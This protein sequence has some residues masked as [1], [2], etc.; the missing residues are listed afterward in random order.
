M[1][2]A[3]GVE[4]P[5]ISTVLYGEDRE[6]IPPAEDVLAILN[7]SI[8]SVRACVYESL[9][10]YKLEFEGPERQ[11]R[12]LLNHNATE[13]MSN[14]DK[15][16]IPSVIFLIIPLHQQRVIGSGRD[17]VRITSFRRLSSAARS[18]RPHRR[19]LCFGASLC[20]LKT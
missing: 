5:K 12:Y 15:R 16:T 8:S 9:R 10:K 4:K 14:E 7:V 13:A 18:S 1:D 20:H 11:K 17:F 2:A 19:G 6:Y 3:L